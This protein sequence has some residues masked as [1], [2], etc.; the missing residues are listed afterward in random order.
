MI[1]KDERKHPIK[2]IIEEIKREQGIIPHRELQSIQDRLNVHKIK[3]SKNRKLTKTFEKDIW[4]IEHVKERN[5]EFNNNQWINRN[6]VEHNL[7]DTGTPITKIPNSAYH[8]R[9]KLK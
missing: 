3:S 1:P 4:E 5:I 9:S 2:K 8:K 6:V 7:K